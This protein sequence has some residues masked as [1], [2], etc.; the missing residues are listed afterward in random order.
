VNLHTQKCI[1]R[2][3]LLYGGGGACS[4]PRAAAAS[5]V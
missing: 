1:I 5:L 2:T 3:F 4:V